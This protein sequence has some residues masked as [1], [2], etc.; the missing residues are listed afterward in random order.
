MT[1]SFDNLL[2]N[3]CWKYKIASFTL[4]YIELNLLFFALFSQLSHFNNLSIFFFL[5]E[6]CQSEWFPISKIGY[7]YSLWLVWL[8]IHNRNC[9]SWTEFCQIECMFISE[10]LISSI[11]FEPFERNAQ[12]ELIETVS[13]TIR[14]LSKWTNRWLVVYE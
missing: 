10:E 2:R 11:Q 13:I 7:E 8:S 3:D 4:I 5:G 14:I 12:P 6:W 1:K 9:K